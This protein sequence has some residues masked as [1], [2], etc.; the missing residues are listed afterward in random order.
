MSQIRRQK[1][2]LLYGLRKINRLFHT[3]TIKLDPN[4]T[5][6]RKGNR[7]PI[8]KLR[9]TKT[10]KRQLS[11]Y[12]DPQHPQQNDDAQRPKVN[13]RTASPGNDSIHVI[14]MLIDKN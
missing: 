3:N 2:Q 8:K 6:Y 9:K 13:S 10:G 14:L 4:A 7:L 1:P 11:F 5:L 12:F